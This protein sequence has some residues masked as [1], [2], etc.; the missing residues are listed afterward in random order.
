VEGLARGVGEVCGEHCDVC[1]CGCGCVRSVVVL[2]LV[3]VDI[4][5]DGRLYHDSIRLNH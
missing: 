2:D 3:K 1:V 4:G 5:D